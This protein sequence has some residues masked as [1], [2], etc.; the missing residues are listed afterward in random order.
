MLPRTF[1]NALQS[2]PRRSSARWRAEHGRLSIPDTPFAPAE[3]GAQNLAKRWVP[4][5]A[6][7]NGAHIFQCNK[8]LS[9]GIS[10]PYV[11]RP[12]RIERR[13][14]RHRSHADAGA[15]VS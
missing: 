10:R 3:A 5:S 7:T 13:G 9:D 11:I 2:I 8:G 12:R 4:A 14:P 15:G 1:A 6:G